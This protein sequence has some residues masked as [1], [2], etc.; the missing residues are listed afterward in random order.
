MARTLVDSSVLV[1]L[2]NEEDSQHE[3]AKKAFSTTQRPLVVHEYVAIECINIALK[4]TEKA[5]ADIFL[6]I[7]LHNSDYEILY[8]QDS[9][10]LSAV[11]EFKKNKTKQLSFVDTALLSLADGYDILTFDET[12]NR[13]IKKKSGK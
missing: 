6:D 4:R 12:L 2:Y 9:G 13:A 8:A 11:A 10:F 1:A 3:K 5:E 7:L